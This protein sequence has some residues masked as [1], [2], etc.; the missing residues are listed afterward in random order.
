MDANYILEQLKYLSGYN[1]ILVPEFTYGDIRIDA[2]IIETSKRWIRG[3]EIKVSRA[4][5][6]SDKKW[7]EY[8]QFC[9]SLS[10]ACPEGLIRK[11]EIDHPFGLL[12][13]C[14]SRDRFHWVKR[15]KNFQKRCSM[16]WYWTYT[17]VLETEFRRIAFGSLGERTKRRD[18]G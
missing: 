9:S 11:E 1:G 12:Y 5:F 2:I 6:L 4:D 10:I 17:K 18:D 7:M 15:P 16:S 8:S 3:F 13:I 14:D